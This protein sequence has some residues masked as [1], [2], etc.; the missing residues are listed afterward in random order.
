M[1]LDSSRIS[2]RPFKLT[3]VDDM[4]LWIDDDRVCMATP[5]VYNHF[6]EVIRLQAFDYVENKVSQRVLEK[7]GFLKEGILRKY[8]YH[9][10][11][12]CMA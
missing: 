1:I 11:K 2:L 10:G 5:Q 3:D 6:A 9:Q 4:M 7:A 12:I 8:C